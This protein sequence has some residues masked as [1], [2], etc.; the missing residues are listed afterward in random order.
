MP[1]PVGKEESRH[2]MFPLIA[3]SKDIR[4]EKNRIVRYVDLAC[5]C[6]HYLGSPVGV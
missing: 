4:C 5:V 1:G 3:L 2:L 6:F